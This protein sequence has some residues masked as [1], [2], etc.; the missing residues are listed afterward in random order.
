MDFPDNAEFREFS[1]STLRDS[2]FLKL[3]EPSK[4]LILTLNRIAYIK[5]IDTIR[6][7]SQYLSIG[8]ATLQTYFK[9]SKKKP[10]SMDPEFLLSI[11]KALGVDPGKL[12]VY[13][14][15][16]EDIDF[17]DPKEE[18]LANCKDLPLPLVVEGM[19]IGFDRLLMISSSERQEI[20]GAKLEVET[21]DEGE[22]KK[23]RVKKVIPF[24]GNSNIVKLLYERME[25]LSFDEEEFYKYSES[26]FGEESLEEL[27]KIWLGSPDP[28]ENFY[29]TG[30]LSH[31]LKK[32]SKDLLLLMNEE[33]AFDGSGKESTV[34]MK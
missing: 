14:N 7:L 12:Y 19:K 4:R 34:T 6:G 1:L 28:I 30:A 2:D 15:A 5:A 29:L 23:K 31:I 26:F 20:L 24:P 22:K 10:A 33:G 27:I 21:G 25:V 11:A 18:F 16:W 32:P 8:S 3:D 17:P 9:G 13:L